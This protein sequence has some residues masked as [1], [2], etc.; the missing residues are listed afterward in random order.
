LLKRTNY[1]KENPLLSCNHISKF[2]YSLKDRKK[3]ITGIIDQ[4]NN[5][6]IEVR[7]NRINLCRFLN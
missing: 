1:M 4:D 2:D 6:L 5:L 7:L 3:E